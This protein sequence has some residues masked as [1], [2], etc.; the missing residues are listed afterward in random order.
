MKIVRYKTTRIIQSVLA[1]ARVRACAH[2][3]NTQNVSV[4]SVLEKLVRELDIQNYEVVRCRNG[5]LK[6]INF[7]VTCTGWNQIHFFHH[8]FR[9][10]K[11]IPI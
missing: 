4:T 8:S 11:S 5:N 7:A 6:D 9:Q 1:C 3:H 2:A 10:R